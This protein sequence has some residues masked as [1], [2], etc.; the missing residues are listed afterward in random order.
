MIV[1]VDSSLLVRAFLGDEDGHDEA[2]RLLDEPTLE[3]VTGTRTRIE[4]A[5]AL[6]RAG[7]AGRGVT[8]ALLAAFSARIDPSEGSVTVLSAPED[9]IEVG[10]LELALKH[11]LR[12]MDAWHLACAGYLLPGV[13]D[14]GE[15]TAFATRDDHQRDVALRLGF[16]AV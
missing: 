8:K 9:K 6:V 4:V 5:C 2:V 16:A 1:Y 10:A 15:P 11:R 7:H 12:A 3:F 14:S 13:S